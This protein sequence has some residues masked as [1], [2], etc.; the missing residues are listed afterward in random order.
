[1]SV[2]STKLCML[3]NSSS[4]MPAALQLNIQLQPSAGASAH[5]GRDAVRLSWQYCR[6]HGDASDLID[7]GGRCRPCLRRAISFTTLRESL[8]PLQST[9]LRLSAAVSQQPAEWDT[10]DSAA[11][12]TLWDG[13]AR[14]RLT[15]PLRKRCST[16][17]TRPG[18]GRA[19]PRFVHAL[20]GRR[21]QY[22]HR[23]PTGE[24]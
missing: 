24:T 18:A 6:Q 11:R 15:L 21:P 2:V 12:N 20:T 22:R 1:M 17:S 10:V 23:L 7:T 16:K 4:Q 5:S 8:Q 13:Y 19:R 3:A 9:A 14:S